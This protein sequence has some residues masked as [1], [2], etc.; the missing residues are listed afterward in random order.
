[1]LGITKAYVSRVGSGPFPTELSDEVGEQMVELEDQADAAVA[2]AR[3][4]PGAE[5][6][7]LPPLEPDF[8]RVRQVEGPEDV[9][10]R[11]LARAGGAGDRQALPRQHG[12]VDRAQDLDAPGPGVPYP[13]ETA[14][15]SAT[16][17]PP[18]TVPLRAA[19]RTR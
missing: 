16:G 18:L 13:F 10:E 1:V 14:R 15:S 7:N 9:Q 17:M 12:Q 5:L 8:A 6:L 4:L 11:A 3:Q 2:H 19:R